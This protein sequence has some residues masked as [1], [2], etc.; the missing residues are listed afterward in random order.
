MKNGA[1]VSK[2]QVLIQFDLDRIARQCKS[3]VSLI[4]LTNSERFELTPLPLRSVKHG[5]PLA[6]GAAFRRRAANRCG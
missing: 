5:E 2:G 1:Q 4:I 3:L 6:R